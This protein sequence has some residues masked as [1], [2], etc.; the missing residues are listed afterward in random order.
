MFQSTI[1]LSIDIDFEVLPA[2]DGLPSQIEIKAVY[3]DATS[4]KSKSGKGRIDILRAL[5]E[6]E[7]LLLED[8]IAESL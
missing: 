2:E 8:E 4:K 1:Q 3:L 6:S 7:V 5:N